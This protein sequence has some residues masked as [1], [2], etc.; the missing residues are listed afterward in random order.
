MTSLYSI[1]KEQ[2]KKHKDKTAV[3]VG[4]KEY[5]YASILLLVNKLSDWLIRNN[6]KPNDRI[7]YYGRNNIEFIIS[8]FATNKCRGVFVP[9][10][11]SISE[12]R[13]DFILNDC[14]PELLIVENQLINDK[15]LNNLKSRKLKFVVVGG[16]NFQQ[17]NIFNWKDIFIED[18]QHQKR[19]CL[20][21][22]LA[23]IIYTSG[24][25]N[26]PKGVMSLNK[27]VLFATQMINSVIKNSSED[28]I[29]CGLPFSFDYGLYQIF[30][31]FSV[32][33]T[34][35]VQDLFFLASIPKYLIEYKITGFPIVPSIL[36]SLY[37]SGL[38]KGLK[39]SNLK[40][41]TSTGDSLPNNVIEYFLTN[42]Q[43]I[44]LIPMYGLTE[45]KRVSIM[46]TENLYLNL[47][48]R[49]SSVGIPLPNTKAIILNDNGEEVP[50]HT[51]GELV[52]I[53]EHVMEGYW[54]NE[55]ETK[56][57]YKIINGIKH[58]YTG[59]LFYKDNDGY[60]Y[61]TGRKEGFIKCRGQKISPKEIENLINSIEYISTSIT[62]GVPD[63][64]TGEAIF[65]FYQLKQNCYQTKNVFFSDCSRYLPSEFRPKYVKLIESNL[66]LTANGKIDRMK[67]RKIAIEAISKKHE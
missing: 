20:K 26:F 51:E 36:L 32:G 14:S 9:L 37:S 24:T 8:L 62:V 67:L 66:P 1:L 10:P 7:I 28:L 3:I 54:N 4:E 5:K 60:L 63:E 17:H 6:I 29:L 21:T 39:Q 31:C 13:M 12:Q 16:E 11:P 48:N 33:A 22:D 57:K 34:L 30:L 49:K 52:V 59:D 56:K 43:S 46:P 64:I 38:L 58:L 41:I 25:T 42:I 44:A 65:I 18:L 55:I 47:I 45:C 40:Y 53:G 35:V 15:I 2:A 23:L 50:P 27:Q 61:F 19:I